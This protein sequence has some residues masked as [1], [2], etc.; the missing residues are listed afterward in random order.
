MNPYQYFSL[1]EVDRWQLKPE[2][3]A[4]ADSARGISGVPY[5]ITS[6]LRTV[7]EETALRGGVRDSAH[8]SGYGFDL[9]CTDGKMLCLIL[10]GLLRAGFLRIG[11]YVD[12]AFNPTHI[13]ADNDPDLLAK[14]GPCIWIKREQNL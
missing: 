4:M 12:A 9:A 6:G 7:A 5:I 11:I 13:H 1:D 14:T 3:W 8:I 2:T 10:L